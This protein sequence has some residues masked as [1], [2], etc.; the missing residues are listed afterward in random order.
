MSNEWYG[1]RGRVKAD[2]PTTV[3]LKASNTAG[4]SLVEITVPVDA[5][6]IIVDADATKIRYV[7]ADSKTA[8][9]TAFATAALHGRFYDL[10][11]AR[12]I[13]RCADKT[14]NLYIV[15]DATSDVTAGL[16]YAFV[17]GDEPRRPNV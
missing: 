10:P 7:W 14:M 12:E 17:I 1:E 13:P 4:A 11:G 2:S 6:A 3:D 8:A 5:V 16:S 9:A 15:N